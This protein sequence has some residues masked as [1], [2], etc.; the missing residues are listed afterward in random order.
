MDILYMNIKMIVTDLDGTLL[1]DDKTVSDRSLSAL[2]RS[3]D[4]G[5]K[6]V[7]ATGRGS[8]SV[9]IVPSELFDGFVINNGAKAYVGDTL[10]Y[11]RLFPIETVRGL[12]L[13][14][15]NAGIKIAAEY[16]GVHYA[17]FNVSKE[18]AWILN[19]EEA[20]FANADFDV[21]KLYAVI[22]SPKVVDLMMKHLSAD[23]HLH[24]TRDG[25]AMVMHKEAQKSSAV[26]ALADYWNIDK[27]ELAAFGDDGNDIDLLEYCG[28]GIAMGNA[29]DEVKAVANQF[30]DTNEND[31]F[32]KWLEENL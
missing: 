10:I 21:E 20:D 24:V 15:D 18:W 6:T 3:R 19:Y 1:R 16:N 4:N 29:I 17:N 25:F 9:T 13:A 14:C 28:I 23:L 26:S 22:D 11:S 2:R 8:N 30:C 31:G 7:Y 32:A 5:I 12:L 27:S